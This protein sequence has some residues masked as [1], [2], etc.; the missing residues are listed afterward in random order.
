MSGGQSLALRREIALSWHRSALA[1]VDPE[2]VPEQVPHEPY[3][4]DSPLLAAARCALDRLADD[5]RGSGWSMLLADRD[6]RVV[7]RW[8]DEPAR[9]DVFEEINVRPG[10]VLREEAVGTNALGTALE[11]GQGLAVHGR[12]HFA[13]DL[14]AFSCYGHPIHHPLTRRIEGVLDVTAV[15]DHADPLLRALVVRAV[16]EIEQGLLDGSR[17]AERHLLH[18]YHAASARRTSP[19]VALDDDLVMAN[20]AAMDLLQP[21]DYGLLRA[22]A[23]TLRDGA[24]ARLDLPLAGGRAVSVTAAHVHGTRGGAVVLLR[25][26]RD[27]RPVGVPAVRAAAD[28]GGAAVLVTGPAGSG[29]TTTAA[30]LAGPGA[31]VLDAADAPDAPDATDATDAAAGPARWARALRAALAGAAPAVCV[32]HVDRLPGPLVQRLV[33]HV[34]GG[35]PP[36]LVLTAGPADTLPD[37][38][39]PLAAVCLERVALPPLAERGPQLHDLATRALREVAPA[40]T[41]RLTPTVVEALAAQEWPGGLHELRAVMRYVGSRR[42]AGDVTLADLP[43]THRAV[44]R[45]RSM[46]GLERAERDAIVRALRAHGGNKR[47]AAADLGVSRTTLYARMRSLRITEV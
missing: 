15:A 47:R 40:S 29:R 9:T 46:A 41:A 36:R 30:E 44:A 35:R 17:S 21:A 10:S 33:A 27:R 43:A 12:E 42:S 39:R 37:A 45:P 24:Q 3:D 20:R 18:A 19:V 32:E 26:A 7:H 23:Q 16:A 6:C 31:V 13:V 4:D 38:V 2:R 14:K 22:L 25:P 5:L 8:L 34:S 28:G 11:T 1:G